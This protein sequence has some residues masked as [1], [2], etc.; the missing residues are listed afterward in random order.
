[1]PG[2]R[3]GQRIFRCCLRDCPRRCSGN[4]NTSAAERLVSEAVFRCVPPL[5]AVSLRKCRALNCPQPA[6]VTG[7]SGSSTR[8]ISSADSS[9]VIAFFSV[10]KRLSFENPCQ[11]LEFHRPIQMHDATHAPIRRL[12]NPLRQHSMCPDSGDFALKRRARVTIWRLSHSRLLL[13]RLPVVIV[14][15]GATVV[16]SAQAGQAPSGLDFGYYRTKIEPIFL[17]DR[18]PDEGAGQ[19]CVNCHSRMVTRLRLQPLTAGAAA[20]TED[21][22]KQNF[23]MVSALVTP[24]DPMKSRLLLHPLAPE[25]GGDPSHTGGKFWKSPDNPEWQAIAAWVQSVQPV[26]FPGWAG[27]TAGKWVPYRWLMIQTIHSSSP[28]AHQPP[29]G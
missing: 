15:F 16:G 9:R 19:R 8:F 14:A 10:K 27:V 28:V 20:W 24:G 4:G 22:S 25:A 26:F 1:M 7:A 29:F 17:K 6:A 13:L 23:Q 18:A 12:N 11:F 5:F 2:V 21:Q 3:G